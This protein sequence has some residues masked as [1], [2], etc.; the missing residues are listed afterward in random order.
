MKNEWGA[1]GCEPISGAGNQTPVF[2]IPSH[3]S[4]CENYTVSTP[5]HDGY[6]IVFNKTNT[7]K[8]ILM[9]MGIFIPKQR[10]AY[11]RI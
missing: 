10:E 9:F 4:S 7:L 11:D 3:L 5:N 8:Q 2:L 6:R 1:R